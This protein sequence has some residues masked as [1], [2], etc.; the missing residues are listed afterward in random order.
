ME[1]FDIFREIFQIQTQTIN[2]WPDP[3]Q[4]ILTWTQH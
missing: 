4:K 3:Y 2:G 1:K